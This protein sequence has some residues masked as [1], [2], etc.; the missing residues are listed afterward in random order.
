VRRQHETSKAK[1]AVNL[2][3]ATTIGGYVQTALPFV[4]PRV[5]I[6]LSV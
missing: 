6:P 3:Y 5:R 4:E 1:L 2:L